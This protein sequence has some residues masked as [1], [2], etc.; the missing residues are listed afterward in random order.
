MNDNL[1]DPHP[2]MID[3]GT[4]WR[5]KHGTAQSPQPIHDNP[6]PNPV[7][8]NPEGFMRWHKKDKLK[9]KQEAEP[10]KPK[11]KPEYFF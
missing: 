2:L 11:D 8:E 6:A 9:P 1:Y 5:C 10:K 4:F 3:S 7:A